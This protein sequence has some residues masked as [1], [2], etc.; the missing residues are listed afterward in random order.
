MTKEQILEILELAR[1][2]KLPPS[3][4]LPMTD[5]KA[6]A[7]AQL[8]GIPRCRLCVPYLTFVKFG[9]WST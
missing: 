8:A 3:D 7:L 4:P 6:A 1:A 9:V 5:A 2:G